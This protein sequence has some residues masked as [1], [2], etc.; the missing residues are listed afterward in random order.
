MERVTLGTL[1]MSGLILAGCGGGSG[2]FAPRA[3]NQTVPASAA[4]HAKS[5]KDAVAAG[6]MRPACGPVPAGRARCVAYVYTAS[7]LR[8]AAAAGRSASSAARATLPDG[9]GPADLQSAYR[10]TNDAKSKG[11][12]ALIA[13]VDAFD[14]PRAEQDLAVYRAMYGLPPCTTANGCFKKVNQSGHAG[15]YPSMPTGD[16]AGWMAETS[17]DLDVVSATCP[18]CRIL[19]VES[20]DDFMNNLGAAVNTAARMG[21][22]AISNSYVAQEQSTDTAPVSQGGELGYY[23]HPGI[24]V[25]AANGDYGYAFSGF[26]FGALIPAA[27]PSVVAVG[28]TELTRDATTS[29]GWTETAWS[30]TGS[31]CSAYEPMPPWQTADGTCVGTYTTQSGRTVSFPSR[32]YGDVAFVAD[33]VAL[34]DTN[35]DGIVNGWGVI[36]G[37]SISA[38]GIAAIYGLSGYGTHGSSD[39]DFPARKL[40]QSRNALY[41]VRAGTNGD[42][43]TSNLCNASTGYD[44]PTGNGSP[45]GIGAF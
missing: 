24:A 30:G 4:H 11:S 3:S 41:D 1:M 20:D 16:A 22:T 15:A 5:L 8:A 37:T 31:G 38:P 6:E 23:L 13:L 43:G 2:S 12:S 21:A 18:K 19:L 36:G 26:S 42:C 9:Y 25:V 45:N 39:D 10:L 33:G 7:G 28:G 17:L 34:Y 27:L 35:P 40:Y 32:I 14:S 29:R 44:G